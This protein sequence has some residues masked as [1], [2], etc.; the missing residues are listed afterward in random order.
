MGQP[1]TFLAIRREGSGGFFHSCYL[2]SYFQ[3]GWGGAAIWNIIEIGGLTMRRAIG[4]WFHDRAAATWTADCTW[5]HTQLD[6]PPKWAVGP[7]GKPQTCADWRYDA[8]HTGKKGCY[9]GGRSC[10]PPD[11]GNCK[12]FSCTPRPPWGCKW[13]CNPSCG[14]IQVYY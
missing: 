9:E 11:N 6:E 10:C 12:Y 8:N 5:D 1:N 13:F 4:D 14:K 7:D 3:S 2:G